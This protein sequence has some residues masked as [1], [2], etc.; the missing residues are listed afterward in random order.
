MKVEISFEIPDVIVRAAPFAALVVLLAVWLVIRV[1]RRRKRERAERLMRSIRTDFIPQ[2]ACDAI[3]E[4]RREVDVSHRLHERRLL[5][6]QWR[7]DGSVLL[8]K[9][10]AKTL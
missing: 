3:E 7:R 10:I 2:G 9:K 8:E 1:R 4:I 6:E 5:E